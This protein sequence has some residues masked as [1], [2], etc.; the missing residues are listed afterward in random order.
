MET[1]NTTPYSLLA[2]PENSHL[3]TN[4]Y[5]YTILEIYFKVN[6]LKQLYRQGWLKKGRDIPKECCESVGDHVFGTIILAVIVRD[7]FFPDIDCSKV[8]LMLAVHELG[9]A[10]DLGDVTPGDDM[11]PEEKH[12]RERKNVIDIFLGLHNCSE[13]LDLWDEFEKGETPE[14]LFA[15]RI[16]ILERS[17]Q[18]KIYSLQHGKDL[19][20]FIEE[21]ITKFGEK[22]HWTELIHAVSQIQ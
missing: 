12:S 13:Y 15:R 9:E 5:V 4:S 11:S 8:V 22:Q 7:R 14:A 21:V 3:K 20:V 19:D 10:G 1:K 16:D 6:H 17:L 2:K 18:A